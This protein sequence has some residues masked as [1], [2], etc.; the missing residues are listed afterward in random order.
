MEFCS[1]SLDK[2]WK[3]KPPFCLAMF[4][5]PVCIEGLLRSVFCSSLECRFLF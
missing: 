1:E 2:V 5:P 4:F 3:G